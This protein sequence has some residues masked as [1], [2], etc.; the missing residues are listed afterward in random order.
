MA[1]QDDIDNL[2][3]QINHER[4]SA[5]LLQDQILKEQQASAQRIDSWQQQA[6]RHN[7]AATRMQQNLESK[8]HQLMHEIEQQAE[9]D[10]HQ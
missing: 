1:T 4:Q 6:R 9:K 5:T 10:R 2:T 7:D 3:N 8:Q